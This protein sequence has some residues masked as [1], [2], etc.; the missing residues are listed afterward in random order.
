MNRPGALT[1][2]AAAVAAV[3]AD[4]DTHISPGDACRSRITGPIHSR[5]QTQHPGVRR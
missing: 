1:R 3:A 2:R 4:A 5:L